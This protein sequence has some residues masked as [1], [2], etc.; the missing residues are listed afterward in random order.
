[1]IKK[2]D[3]KFIVYDKDGKR[4]GSYTTRAKA[5]A[6]V[7]IAKSKDKAKDYKDESAD[8]PE[9]IAGTY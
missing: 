2:E 5:Q 4:L 7:I 9:N 3:G 1:M 6:K 8:M